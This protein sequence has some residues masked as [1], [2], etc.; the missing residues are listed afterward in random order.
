MAKQK[1]KGKL[2]HHHTVIDPDTGG[3]VAVCIVKLETGG[4]IG[5]DASFLEN[6]EEPVYSPFDKNVEIDL[7]F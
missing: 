3:E 1:I 4:I 2:V 5:I 6:T 7:D